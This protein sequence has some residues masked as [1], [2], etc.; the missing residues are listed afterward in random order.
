MEDRKHN[1]NLVVAKKGNDQRLDHELCHIDLYLRDY[2]DLSFMVQSLVIISLETT[3][4]IKM[5]LDILLSIFN[6]V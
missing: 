2:Y 5:K 3:W 4:W 1:A 6:Q